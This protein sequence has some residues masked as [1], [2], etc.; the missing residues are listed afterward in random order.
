[1]GNVT[2]NI[3][4]HTD[5][6]DADV[7]GADVITTWLDSII[8]KKPKCM[9]RENFLLFEDLFS[10]NSCMSRP[11][12]RFRCRRGTLNMSLCI[13]CLA[14]REPQYQA[15]TASQMTGLISFVWYP[16]RLLNFFLC[17]SSEKYQNELGTHYN[18]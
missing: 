10:D 16:R 6:F 8:L 2:T 5:N 15:R 14:S 13:I 4:Q 11:M 7:H 18:C 12:A 1:M 3:L 9:V 17:T